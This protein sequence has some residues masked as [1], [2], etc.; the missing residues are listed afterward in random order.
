MSSA[1]V[2]KTT[3]TNFH[4]SFVSSPRTSV[5]GATQSDMSRPIV[6][7]GINHLMYALLKRIHSLINLCPSC[8]ELHFQLVAIKNRALETSPQHKAKWKDPSSN[9]PF[10]FLSPVSQIRLVKGSEG[11]FMF[12]FVTKLADYQLTYV[13]IRVHCCNSYWYITTCMYIV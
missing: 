4:T 1:Q 7:F 5:C 11:N 2:W 12:M 3:P 6:F 10:K 8:K 13:G 9:R